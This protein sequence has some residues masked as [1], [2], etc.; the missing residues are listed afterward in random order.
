MLSEGETSQTKEEENNTM[1][2]IKPEALTT[3]ILHCADLHSEEQQK[4]KIL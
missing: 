3:K 4:D 1:L 2:I